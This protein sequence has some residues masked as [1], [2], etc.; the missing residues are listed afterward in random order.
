MC[1]QALP[2]SRRLS[3]RRV[4]KGAVRAGWSWGVWEWRASDCLDL[5][6]LPKRSDVSCFVFPVSCS[7]RR[8]S[9]GECVCVC[10]DP[11]SNHST[12]QVIE[13]SINH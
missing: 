9:A 10:L 5:P 6:A 8:R 2:R 3:E 1:P 4:P 13:L 11:S 12:P 7:G